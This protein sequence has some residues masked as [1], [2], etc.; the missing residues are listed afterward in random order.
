MLDFLELGIVLD[1]CVVGDGACSGGKCMPYRRR[2]DECSRGL[3]R[4][5]FYAFTLRLGARVCAVDIVLAVE[6]KLCN[7]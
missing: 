1:R 7:E 6:L 2:A 4:H 5:C 3:P